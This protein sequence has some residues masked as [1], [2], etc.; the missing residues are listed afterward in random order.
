MQDPATKNEENRRTDAW[1]PAT[2]PA[3][4]S[5]A[6]LATAAGRYSLLDEIAHGGMGVVYRATDTVLG[7][8]VAVK[9][10]QDR[11]EAGSAVARR[12]IDEARITGQ[13]QHPGVPAVHD[14]G[15]LADG[16]PFL[17]MKLIKGQTLDALLCDRTDPAADRGRFVAAFE[18]VCQTV[19]YAHA[20]GVI[21]RDLKPANIMV[22]AFGE[23]QV[24]DGGLAK[25]LANQ[26]QERSAAPEETTAGTAIRSLR[27]GGGSETQ[28]GSVLGTP[29]FMP[30][31]Q[32]AGAV[33]LI[34][35]Q[36]DVF[37]LGAILAVILT[38]QPPFVGKTA[39][40]VRVLAA[41]GK[42]EDC[43]ARLDARAR[44]GTSWPCARSA[45]RRTRRSGR[46][47]LARWRR[48]WRRCGRRR[49]SGRGRRTWSGL[50]PW[51]GR[52]GGACN[53][54]WP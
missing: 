45:W 16:R 6:T 3:A 52:S 34:D 30:P 50:V 42:V 18:Q 17:A 38:G 49:T 12:F 4:G 33:H 13:L 46:R 27:E 24:M 44:T 5:P 39:E 48:R 32:A 36:S 35:E 11:F 25:V 37:G 54:P 29:A 28:A 53:G 1:E 2:S 15:T 19:G 14:L 41:R 43:F 9:V 23:V 51:S 21:H 10:L 22:G 8:E 20:H 31:E 26:P 47:T 7:R 40:D